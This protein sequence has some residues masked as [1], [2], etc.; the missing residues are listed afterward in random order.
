MPPNSDKKVSKLN[1]D[2]LEGKDAG[3]LSPILRAQQTNEQCCTKEDSP[4]QVNR[5]SIN[6]PVAGVLVI[7]GTSYVNSERNVAV[8]YTLTPKVDDVTA[9]SDVGGDYFDA[10]AD[11]F[12]GDTSG[13]SYTVSQPVKPGQHTVTQVV[14]DVSGG[15]PCEPTFSYGNNEL[16]VL[17]VPGAQASVSFFQP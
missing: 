9:T 15:V 12:F 1:A 6:A 13:L 16:S 2:Q 17:F 4:K 14:R 8:G 3:Q 5:V 7:S 10:N 11:T